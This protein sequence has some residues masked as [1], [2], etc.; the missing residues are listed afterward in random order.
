MFR[1]FIAPEVGFFECLRDYFK[2][3]ANFE[4]DKKLKCCWKV[5]GRNTEKIKQPRP[6]LDSLF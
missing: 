2:K 6:I 5:L 3:M 1:N 4:R